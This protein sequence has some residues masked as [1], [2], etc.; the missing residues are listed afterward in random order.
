MTKGHPIHT[1]HTKGEKKHEKKPKHPEE[2][3]Y[4]DEGEWVDEE[5]G[6]GGAPDAGA[7]VIDLRE[8][9]AQL[10]R[11]YGPAPIASAVS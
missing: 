6:E 8:L 10:D 11:I 5:E 2:E 1:T 9:K 7:I 3:E 4:E